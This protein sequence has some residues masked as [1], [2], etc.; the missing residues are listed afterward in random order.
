MTKAAQS[1]RNR[2]RKVIKAELA[3]V[4][5]F[6]VDPELIYRFD[7][8]IFFPALQNPGW[9]EYHTRDSYYSKDSKDGKHKKGEL[10]AKKGERK[11]KTRY[12]RIDVDNRVK[13][14]Q[15]CVS[16]LIGLPDDSN[17]FI[18]HQE[19][20]EDPVQP[21]S[22]VRVTVIDPDQFFKKGGTSHARGA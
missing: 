10:K 7:L 14:L 20:H 1:F 17:I 4:L 21:R 19:K 13:F 3:A 12:K 15:D 6:P 8:L 18:G 9:F 11:A 16:K 2:M 22:E 5:D